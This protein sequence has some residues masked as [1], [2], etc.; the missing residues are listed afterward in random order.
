MQRKRTPYVVRLLA[1]SGSLLVSAILWRFIVW[2]IDHAPS[3]LSHSPHHHDVRDDLLH[4]DVNVMTNKNLYDKFLA[5]VSTRR[6][7]DPRD[8]SFWPVRNSRTLSTRRYIH[9][10]Y[11]IQSVCRFRVPEP[12]STFLRTGKLIEATT[13]GCWEKAISVAFLDT[14]LLASSQTPRLRGP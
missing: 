8:M 7:T 3:D 1:L 10:H 9:A 11:C 4:E 12:D 13:A 6:A 2:L 14:G 5:I